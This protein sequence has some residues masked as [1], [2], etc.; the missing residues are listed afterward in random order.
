MSFF[1]NIEARANEQAQAEKKEDTG[2]QFD[3]TN[4]MDFGDGANFSF[5]EDGNAETAESE[6]AEASKDEAPKAEEPAPVVKE[7]TEAVAEPKAKEEPVEESVKEET[8]APKAEEAQTDEDKSEEEKPA[9]KTRRRRSKKA[10]TEEENAEEKTAEVEAE[11]KAAKEAKEVDVSK[12]TEFQSHGTFD[13]FTDTLAMAISEEGREQKE[14][15]NFVKTVQD[16]LNGDARITADINLGT[17]F[18]VS[19]EL[20]NLKQITELMHAKYAARL[21]QLVDKECGFIPTIR[22]AVVSDMGGKP[23]TQERDAK[24]RKALQSAKIGGKKVNLL[25]YKMT[26]D[27]R[28]IQIQAFLNIIDAKMK[29]LPSVQ[30]A[31]KFDNISMNTK[32]IRA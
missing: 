32:S 7:K 10:K 15:E 4:G 12:M 28:L 8:E 1:G 21:K 14:Y 25:M 2:F 23:S 20:D 18:I 11:V 30:G 5:F 22:D 26:I 29:A 6:K 27:T 19:D 13:S 9:K 16:A 3:F 24:V 17:F 31:L